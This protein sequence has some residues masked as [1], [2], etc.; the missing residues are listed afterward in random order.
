MKRPTD[1]TIAELFNRHAS[2]LLL[3]ARQWN[4]AAA[5]DDVVQRVFV[6]LLADGKLPVDPRTWLFRCV[7]NEAISAWRSDQR[8]TQ[9]ERSAAEDAPPWFVSGVEDAIDAS[10]AQQAMAQLPAEQ[11]E[12]VALRI[13]SGLTLAQVAEVTGLAISSVHHQ[14]NLALATMRQRLETPCKSKPPT[15]ATGN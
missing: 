15:S 4:G 6:R 2:A 8:R 5:A 13:W 7:R 10:A 1:D 14:L 3:Y 12:I 9:R 11:R